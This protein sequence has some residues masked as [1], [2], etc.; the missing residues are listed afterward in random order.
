MLPAVNG[1]PEHGDPALLMKVGERI[2]N[3]ERAFNARDGFSRKDDT[4][5]ERMRSGKVSFH[6][7]I[8]ILRAP[9]IS[10]ITPTGP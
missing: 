10:H 5:P 3:L 6:L 4:L 1:I 7:A 2:C 8:Y 9:R